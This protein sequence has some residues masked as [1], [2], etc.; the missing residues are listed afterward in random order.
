MHAPLRASMQLFAEPRVA[1]LRQVQLLIT[2]LALTCGLQRVLMQRFSEPRRRGPI[3]QPLLIKCGPL[4][5][6]MKPFA[7][8]QAAISNAPLVYLVCFVDSLSILLR[9]VLCKPNISPDC[10]AA[11]L[12]I[13]PSPGLTNET[14][15]AIRLSG[16]SGSRT[17]GTIP[18][19]PL[20][21]TWI[22]LRLQ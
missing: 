14:Q 7:D 4:R 1:M 8:L 6:S 9:R 2:R 17:V 5:A 16:R 10:A 11:I 15:N 13:D 19:G 20:E 12:H 18:D 22:E 21:R 3:L